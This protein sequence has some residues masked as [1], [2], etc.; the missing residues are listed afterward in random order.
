MD[1]AQPFVLV[2]RQVAADEVVE[3]RPAAHDSSSSCAREHP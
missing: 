1:A 2:R 3:V